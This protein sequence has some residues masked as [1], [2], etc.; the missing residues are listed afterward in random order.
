MQGLRAPVK[1]ISQKEILDPDIRIAGVCLEGAPAWR[2]GFWAS[3]QGKKRVE[4]IDWFYNILTAP[5]P[6][7]EVLIPETA[8]LCED[9]FITKRLS[10]LMKAAVL[11]VCQDLDAI[12]ASEIA[13]RIASV[14][15]NPSARTSTRS[16]GS[17]E[18]HREARRYSMALETPEIFT[19]TGSEEQTSNPAD[20]AAVWT[21]SELVLTDT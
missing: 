15:E 2:W 16:S 3:S 12:W 13:A 1:Q 18:L 4:K 21:I 8:S 10:P 6:M 14:S 19:D 20:A 17:G 7:R 5:C 9:P 11:R